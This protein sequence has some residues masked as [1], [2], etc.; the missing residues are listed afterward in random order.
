MARLPQPGGDAGN[1]GDILNDY[2]NQSHK[3]DGTIKDNAVTAA[4]LAPNSVTNA[5]LASDSVNATTIADGSVTEPLLSAAV[6]TKLNAP[7][8]IDDG[9]ITKPKLASSVQL[10]LDKAD[11][12]IATTDLDTQNTTLIQNN[13]SATRVAL[14]ALYS[15]GGGTTAGISATRIPDMLNSWHAYPDFVYDSVRR[16]AYITGSSRGGAVNVGW[17]DLA[18]KTVGRKVISQE[19]HAADDHYTRSIMLREGKQPFIVGAYHDRDAMLR[20]IKGKSYGEFDM[21]DNE[22]NTTPTGVDAVAYGQII[23]PNPNNIDNGFGVMFRGN[24][25][26]M[27]MRTTDAATTWSEGPYLFHTKAYSMH[28]RNGNIGHFLAFDHPT[29]T[30]P[31]IRYFKYALSAGGGSP[32]NAAGAGI[33]SPGVTGTDI[34][35]HTPPDT[36]TSIV[37]TNSTDLVRSAPAGQSQRAFDMTRNA[38]YILIGVYADKNALDVGC[39]YKVLSRQTSDTTNTWATEDVTVSG[40]SFG[41]SGYVGG[42]NFAADGSLLI[43]INRS[44]GVKTLERWVRTGSDFSTGTWA[45]DRVLYTAPAG[46]VALGRPRVPIDCNNN[47]AIIPNIVTFGEYHYYDPTSFLNFYGDQVVIEF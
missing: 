24:S 10:S 3:T 7:A 35:N 14:D 9:T 26:N 34:W 12:S 47:N 29:A 15:S 1:W 39:S 37:A 27:L 43:I 17:F 22:I 2:L 42:G 45:L 16:R 33:L 28:R 31:Q 30:T 23:G 8:N 5:A 41:P 25:M 46:I 32:K 6:Q 44:G 40:P 18:S 11:S 13:S 20:T 21:I 36:S 19:R 38:R 4:A